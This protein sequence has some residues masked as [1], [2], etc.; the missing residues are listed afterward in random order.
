[1]KFFLRI[2][3]KNKEREGEPTI[4]L[5]WWAYCC[6]REGCPKSGLVVRQVLEKEAE[7]FGSSNNMIF[8]R[9]SLV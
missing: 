3:S 2:R 6:S 9:V 7:S 8:F 4:T 5:A 1:M